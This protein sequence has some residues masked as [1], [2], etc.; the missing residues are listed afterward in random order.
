MTYMNDSGNSTSTTSREP[1]VKN[2]KLDQADLS[3][4]LDQADLNHN[5]D[6]AD[7]DH[8]MI[9]QSST[10]HSMHKHHRHHLLPPGLPL[11]P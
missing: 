11:S 7:L 8:N 1:P 2:N 9:K 4:N 5:L 6:Q 10:P 3:H